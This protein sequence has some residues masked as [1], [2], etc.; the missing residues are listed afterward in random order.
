MMNISIKIYTL[1]GTILYIIIFPTV[2]RSVG[3]NIIIESYFDAKHYLQ[4]RI[5]HDHQETL[6]CGVMYDIDG[7]INLPHDFTITA[8][9]QRTI[10]VEWE[11]VVPAENFGRAFAEWREGHH[12]CVD[13]KRKSFKGRRCAEK[14][15][16]E[17][18]LMQADMYNL[19]PAIGAVNAMRSNLNYATLP[20][21]P[22]K[23]GSCEM[24]IRGKKVEPSDRSKGQVARASLYMDDAY[25]SRFRLSRQQRR[26]FMAWDKQFPVNEWE[27]RRTKRIEAIQRNTNKFVKGPCQSFGLW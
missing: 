19:F 20:S 2:V 27:C 26:L 9:K 14:V 21:A 12:Q 13:S 17:Y 1:L 11:H 15:S 22:F 10:K 24:K 16:R 25:R 8:Y 23:F 6:Y 3:G 18:R 7:H 5:Y 4:S